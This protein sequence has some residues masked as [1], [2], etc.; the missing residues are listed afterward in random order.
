MAKKSPTP[1]EQVDTE[2]TH[3]ADLE[4]SLRA[5][6]ERPFSEAVK[7]ARRELELIR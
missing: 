7:R 3:L 6:G 1:A 4:L 2:I 5:R